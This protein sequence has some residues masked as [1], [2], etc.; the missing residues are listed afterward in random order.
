MRIKSS[1]FGLQKKRYK[2]YRKDPQD[3]IKECSNVRGPPTICIHKVDL[4]MVCILV[5]MSKKIRK[6]K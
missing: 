5:L 4:F 6:T 2:R 1:N 3:S